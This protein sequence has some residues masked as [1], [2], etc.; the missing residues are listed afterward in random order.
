MKRLR[1]MAVLAASAAAL[2]SGAGAWA[3]IGGG[4]PPATFRVQLDGEAVVTATGY[5]L[6]AALA[7]GDKREYTLRLSLRL[8]DNAAPA[9]AFQTGQTFASAAVELVAS[10]QTV[11]KTYSLVNATVIGYRQRGDAGTNTFEQQLV[12]RSRSLAI[13]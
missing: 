11:M 5:E 2:A 13:G 9:Q 1:A 3:L 7:A 6:D 4:T 10:D 8:T 12:L